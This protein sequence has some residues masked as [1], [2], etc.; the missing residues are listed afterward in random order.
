MRAGL[1]CSRL[2]RGAAHGTVRF[3]DR[4]QLV[5]R[6]RVPLAGRLRHR[7]GRQ[8][9]AHHPEIDPA[10]IKVDPAD[11]DPDASTDRIPHPGPFAERVQVMRTLVARTAHPQLRMVT[12]TPGT[13]RAALD[14]QLAEVVAAGGE[15]LMLHHRD[16]R[17]GAGRSAALLKFK[18]HDDA[19]ARVVAHT[20][21][22]GKY[23]GM[24]GALEVEHHDGRR[25]RI[26][27]GFSDAQR[28]QPPALGT[29]VT[30]RYN[31]LTSTGL[32]RFARFLRVRDEMP[33]PE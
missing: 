33:P 24:L 30:Y 5:L 4:G 14:A 25:V 6:R 8:R 15:G 27:T 20:P 28:A 21:G 17:Y 9:I 32:P 19:E 26:G 23:S 22:K 10:P 1:A 18:P 16:A 3:L 11:L 7:R 29:W 13:S 2:A 12:Q 31:G